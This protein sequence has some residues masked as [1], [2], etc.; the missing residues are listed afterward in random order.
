MQSLIIEGGKRLSGEIRLQGSKNSALPII[1]GSVLCENECLLKNCPRLS[2]VF[3]SARIITALGG[4]CRIDGNDFSVNTKSINKTSISNEL[5]RLMRSSIIYLGAVLGRFGECRVSFP[6]G[7]EL[8]ARP[9]DIHLSA[10]RKMG[11]VIK[12]EYGELIC[13]AE[14]GLYGAEVVLPFP[15]VG[16]TENIILAAAKAQGTTVIKNAAREPEIADLCGFLSECGAEISGGGESTIIIRG[17]KT[18]HGCEYVIMPD[19][20][21]AATYISAAAATGGSLTVTDVR[22]ADMDGIISVFEEMGCRIYRYKSHIFAD[23]SRQLKAVKKVITM[24]YPGFPTDA[25]PVIMAALLKAKG[26]S[27][28]VENIFENRYRHAEE[29]LKMGADIKTEGKTAVV[30]GVKKLY[31]AELEAADLR[32]GAALAVAALAAD[33]KSV[34]TNVK[35]IDR[36]YEAFEDVL[37][38]VG[39]L[40]ERKYN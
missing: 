4:M 7:C 37:C 18:L 2:D 12:E 32:G 1:A 30:S 24:P 15:S 16:A 33:G 25:Q 17:V 13:T 39:A 10:L 34:I 40:A 29:M 9:I 19:R 3:A 38:A 31:G 22:A 14:K 21:A 23:C 28:F 26:S 35:Y 6:G 27:M 11:A 8:G 5:M 20:I 36:G